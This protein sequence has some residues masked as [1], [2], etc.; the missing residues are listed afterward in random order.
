MAGSEAFDDHVGSAI[1][2]WVIGMIF[3]G[4][5]LVRNS[6]LTMTTIKDISLVEQAISDKDTQNIVLLCGINNLLRGDSE[7]SS[8][9]DYKRLLKQTKKLLPTGKIIV[10]GVIPVLFFLIPNLFWWFVYT[11]HG[12]SFYPV[13]DSHFPSGLDA[14]ALGILLAGMESRKWIPKSFQVWGNLGFPLLLLTMIA[15]TAGSLYVQGSIFSELIRWM[16]MLS[17]LLFISVLAA[18]IVYRYISLPILR[19]SMSNRPR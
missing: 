12:P 4:E 19:I 11:G 5:K 3:Y 15:M 17:S 1:L 18:C 16:A 8:L 9:R 10:L 2:S 6:G 7:V 13:I 14:F